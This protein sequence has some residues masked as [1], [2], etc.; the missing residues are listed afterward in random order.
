MNLYTYVANN[1]P[2]MAKAICH[3]YGYKISGVQTKDDLGVVL[4]QLVSK[5]GEP[6]LKDIVLNH[7]DRDI[8]IEFENKDKVESGINFQGNPSTCPRCARSMESCLCKKQYANYVNYIGEDRDIQPKQTQNA[9]LVS[10][11]NTFL[12]ASAFLLG[13]A[14]ISRK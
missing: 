13:V 10:Q 5:E 2:S 14:I 11:T 12:L 4:E 6:A 3:K 7:P 9:S 1:N 8:I